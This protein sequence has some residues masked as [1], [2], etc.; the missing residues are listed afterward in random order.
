LTSERHHHSVARRFGGGAGQNRAPDP[1]V[2]KRGQVGAG[3]AAAV[4][5]GY[6]D[7]TENRRLS[8][9]E[10]RIRRRNCQEREVRKQLRRGYRRRRRQR[11]R[12]SL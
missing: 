8:P 1:V 2:E 12:S 5:A 10:S 9:A 11:G 7:G 4:E 3:Y 6:F